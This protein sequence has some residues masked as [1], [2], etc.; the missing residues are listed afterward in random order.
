MGKQTEVDKTEA[1]LKTQTQLQGD[2]NNKSKE[3]PEPEPEKIPRGLG[4]HSNKHKL[5]EWH[6]RG[7]IGIAMY[8][9]EG[10]ENDEGTNTHNT[11]DNLDES[12]LNK[13]DN[14]KER[15]EID[16]KDIN[17]GGNKEQ[18]WAEN[19][20]SHSTKKTK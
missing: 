4:K 12:T 20:K 3:G 7:K 6:E 1:G 9:V 13:N 11:Y 10:E 8:T 17:G 18:E 14:N 5:P 2:E 15:K 19:E 16:D